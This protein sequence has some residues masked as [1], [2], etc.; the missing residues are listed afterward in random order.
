M[1]TYTLCALYPISQHTRN[2]AGELRLVAV[3]RHPIARWGSLT[4][5]ASGC[6]A[7]E[8][9]RIMSI[10]QFLFAKQRNPSGGCADLDKHFY[11]PRSAVWVFII[12]YS[13]APTIFITQP[14]T[15]AARCSGDLQCISRRMPFPRK[16]HHDRPS[17]E[18]LGS[19]CQL[20]RTL[21]SLSCQFW[22]ALG[23]EGC[24][25]MSITKKHTGL[26]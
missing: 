1:D 16:D 18:E 22:W 9:S 3:L 11:A 26:L 19:L 2:R 7:N 21:S 24:S 17:S 8:V 12:M 10:P 14:S 5:I 6:Q 13:C 23:G 4:Y 20:L 25:H 15:T